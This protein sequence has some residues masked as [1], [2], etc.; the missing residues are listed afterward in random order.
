MTISLAGISQPG[1]AN[2]LWAGSE[3][4]IKKNSG[5]PEGR[6]LKVDR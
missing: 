5:R 6:P 2:Q 1:P 4:K 3:P